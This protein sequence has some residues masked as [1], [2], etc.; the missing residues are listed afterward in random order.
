MFSSTIALGSQSGASIW[1]GNQHVCVARQHPFAV[2][3]FE[4]CQCITFALYRATTIRRRYD[5]CE[6]GPHKSPVSD[7]LDFLNVARSVKLRCIWSYLIARRSSEVRFVHD[8]SAGYQKDSIIRHERQNRI[9][10]TRL[11][12]RHPGGNKVA[13][14]LFVVLHIRIMQSRCRLS[15]AVMSYGPKTQWRYI[16]FAL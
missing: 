10:I 8:W 1:N 11:A 13:C 15:G 9:N 2:L 6:F 7:D 3:F 4:D 12:C 14:F 16:W 5:N